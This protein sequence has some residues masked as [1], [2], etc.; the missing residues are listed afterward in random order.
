MALPS[1]SGQQVQAIMGVFKRKVE[2]LQV[3]ELP[4]DEV[5]E[6]IFQLTKVTLK[7][8]LINFIVELTE[9]K[10]T[11]DLAEFM[12]IT[13]KVLS[14]TTEWGTLST[15][16]D[17]EVGFHRI[18]QQIQSRLLKRGFEFNVVVVG[19]TGLG[20]ST[21]INTI[22]KS[23]VARTSI[24]GEVTPPA[25][26]LQIHTISHVLEEEGLRLKLSVTD[27]PG[28]GDAI[29]NSN[30]WDPI[31]K[32]IESQLSLYLDAELDVERTASIPDTRIHAC[33]YFIPPT[34]HGLRELDIAA[35][36]A[37]QETVNVIP[38]I[39]KADTLTPQELL[40]FKETLRDEMLSADIYPYPRTE[41]AD[42]DD[43]KL[44]VLAIQEQLPFAVVGHNHSVRKDDG[45]VVR[46]RRTRNGFVSIDDGAHCDLASLCDVLIRDRMDDLIQTTALFHYESYRR[47]NVVQG[48][49]ADLDVSEGTTDA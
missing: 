18:H 1:L 43:E 14:R 16:T 17:G 41:Y 47:R 10:E 32:H 39:A 15:P 7:D 20:K 25:S 35:M 36:K 27:T 38:V 3:Q 22:F 29:D 46:G 37:L 44:A 30:C 28:F 4:A 2:E 21:L 6:L 13:L 9:R 8:S 33:L 31:V 26:T 24:E 42:D 48:D 40:Q 49:S 5:E 45:L 12:N 34:G 23:T 19:N 11:L